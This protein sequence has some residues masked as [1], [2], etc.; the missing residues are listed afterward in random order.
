MK[1]I[2]ICLALMAI[3]VSLLLLV[4]CEL[5]VLPMSTTATTTEA[6][7][8]APIT[9]FDPHVHTPVTVRG[10]APTCTQ[11]GVTDGIK[12]EQCGEVLVAQELIP[13]KG[14]STPVPI[15]GIAPTCTEAGLTE[16][17]RCSECGEVLVKQEEIPALGHTSVTD[18]AVAP[19]CTEA[20]LT[21]GAH[22]GVCNFPL[23]YQ[24][25]IEPLGHGYKNGECPACGETILYLR[26]ENNYLYFG[27]YP[28][29]LKAEDVTVGDTAD[30]RGYYLGSDGYY[31]ARVTADV[32]Y[33]AGGVNYTYTFSDGTEVESGEVYYFKVEP[34]LWRILY[35]DCETAFL[36]CDSI[37]TP[38]AYQPGYAVE[39]SKYV[40]SANGAPDGTAANDYRYSEI[41]RW[42]NAEFYNTAFQSLQKE[43]ILKTELYDIAAE[44]SV[45][46]LSQTEEAALGWR[47]DFRKVT[48]DYSRAMG[49]WMDAKTGTGRGTWWL[50]S[51]EN[52][53]NSRGE[54]VLCMDETAE[55]FT[56]NSMEAHYGVA[57]ALR[58]ALTVDGR[59]HDLVT[60]AA[61]APTCIKTGL[62]EGSHCS[63]CKTVIV[64]Q[65]VLDA[66]GHT[67]ENGECTR[68][69][70]D[71][72]PSYLR[73]GDYIL[74]GEYPQ[75]LKD[76]GVTVSDTADG[77][78][79]YLGSD[80]AYYAKVTATPYGNNYTFT[81]GTAVAD[82]T[83]YYFKVEPI[84][85]RIL[86]E[87]NGRALVLC[88]SIIANMA[89]QTD[90]YSVVGEGS[91][92]HGNGAPEGTRPNNYR[93]SDIRQWLNA[94]F[95]NTVFSEL[96]KQIILKATVDNSGK[97]TDF[98]NNMYA[99]EDTE[100]MLFLL[101]FADAGSSAY[102]SGNAARMVK[103][104][105]Y[106]RATGAYMYVPENGVTSSKAAGC[107]V[108]WLRSPC[109]NYAM[110]VEAVDYL[111]NYLND[112][113]GSVSH[114]HCG[115]LPAMWLEL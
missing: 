41:R 32:Y 57:P 114:E 27:E 94:E 74:F 12:C 6:V 92:T 98:D 15:G 25:E 37:L 104:C 107:G 34:I 80:G 49:A 52:G 71:E 85:W 31:Y 33:L 55:I 86:T 103:V 84:R 63:V 14:H 59:P 62:T 5:A 54:L 90:T 110:G 10:V 3:L 28:Q 93:Y 64:A 115:I 39:N 47:F 73:E 4:A 50:R 23:A 77:R 35:E 67:F 26:G 56:A 53:G 45:F 72:D 82:G 113:F 70:A 11:S 89:Y 21:E 46:L 24:W 43:L 75:S 83:C 7:T 8:T 1:R 81:D 18:P 69:L 95:Y 88:D 51:P 44:D 112:N 99:C 58:I 79:Y 40:T 42:L 96:Q 108:W 2:R 109:Y 30:S 68:C 106:S 61:V 76:E 78:G 66:L 111:G 13:A 22:C 102:F 87:E 105:D 20:G 29:T 9:V 17:G 91:Y 101:S 16:G 48:T 97:T 60:D 19:T 65:T 38:M 100:D 36:L